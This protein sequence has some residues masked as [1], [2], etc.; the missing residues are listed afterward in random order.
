MKQGAG[1]VLSHR[2]LSFDPVHSNDEIQEG[3]ADGEDSAC[4]AG[5]H[6]VLSYA[7]CLNRVRD[8]AAGSHTPLTLNGKHA[9]SDAWFELNSCSLKR[10]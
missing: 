1:D 3:A 2:R 5:E 4:S 8:R 9:S 10:K 6:D 7:R